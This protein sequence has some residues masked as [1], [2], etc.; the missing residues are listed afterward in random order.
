MTHL[1]AL[2][3]ELL[4][5][6]RRRRARE[7]FATGAD[8]WDI[9]SETRPSGRLTSRQIGKW[10]VVT[11]AGRLDASLAPELKSHCDQALSHS[12]YLI[13]DLSAA[14]GVDDAIVDLLTGMATLLRAF[15]GSLR[16]VGRRRAS[17]SRN[18]EDSGE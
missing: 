2:D 11:A 15:G 5:R 8:P 13:V 10:T 7:G 1:P 17:G 3:G 6:A 9:A 12:N 4:A 14:H 16:T 18:N